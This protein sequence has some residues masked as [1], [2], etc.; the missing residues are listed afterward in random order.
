M[1]GLMK[2]GILDGFMVPSGLTG[3]NPMATAL[4]IKSRK[5][6]VPSEQILTVADT[7]FVLGTRESFT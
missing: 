3:K 5:L 6:S 7:S 2:M 4:L 1:N